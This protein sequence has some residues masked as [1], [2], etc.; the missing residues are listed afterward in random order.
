MSYPPRRCVAQYLFSNIKLN[1]GFVAASVTDHLDELFSFVL[2]RYRF[3]V[4][5]NSP[6][7]SRRARCDDRTADAVDKIEQLTNFQ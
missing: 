3:F 2:C 4:H 5:T 6:C 7:K 1:N